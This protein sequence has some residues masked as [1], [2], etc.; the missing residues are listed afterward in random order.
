MVM[1]IRNEADHLEIAIDSV[2][3]QAYPGR[4]RIVL[5]VGPSTDGTEALADSIAAQSDDLTVVANPSGKT[6]SALNAAIRAGK[7]PVIVRVDGHSELSAGYLRRA[8]EI[9]R[10]TGAANDERTRPT[11]GCDRRPARSPVPRMTGWPR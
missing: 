7:A 9:L 8:V 10:E 6:P 1:P 4:V 11:V 3:R 2:R 5:G